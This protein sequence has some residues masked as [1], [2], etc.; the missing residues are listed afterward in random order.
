M[1]INMLS[2]LNK[3]NNFN[4]Y[5]STY[6]NIVSLRK[7]YISPSVDTFQAF[8]KPLILKK[9]YMQYVWDYEDN[10][11]IDLVSQNICISVGHSHPKIISK[12]YEQMSK[13][14]HCSTMYYHEK[15][16]LLSKKIIE[17]LPR[18]PSGDDWVIHFVNNGSEAVDLATQM[19]RVYT[20]RPEIIALHK[21]YHGLQGYAA[22]LTSIGVATQKCNSSIYNSITHLEP[23]NLYQLEQH[24]KYS[25]SGKIGG[26]ILEPLQGYGGIYPLDKDYMKSSFEL[27]KHYGGVTIVDEV[28]T[29]Y[30]RCGESFWGFELKNND[31]IPDIIT[32]AKGMGNGIGIIG[33]VISRR[34][35]AEAFSEKMFF[36]TYGSNPT[37][38]AAAIEVIN[39]IKNENILQN[40][41][42]Q[43]KLFYKKLNELCY[44]YPYIYKEVR[45][46]GLFL[47]LE[48]YGDT[49][50]KSKHN[51]KKLH[52]LTLKYGILIGCGSA[53]GNLFRIQPPM[54]INETD[55]NNVID[56]LENLA[57]E[58]VNV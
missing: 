13:L 12:T 33:A 17:L 3:I 50:E 31:V 7:K 8:N 22:G 38:C 10:K 24:L 34:S 54:C 53:Q 11:Y 25:S 58:W 43:G 26:I 42:N 39:V 2:K 20:N 37:A 35:I 40:C 5:Y 16:S 49:N 23:N 57:N 30:G 52:E 36:N 4:K 48:I 46:S 47:G 55:V 44:K 6:S 21:A 1:I 32:I 51:A 14:P 56:A 41:F 19:A 27:I 29:G 9:G 45:G 15:P 18:H 28:Q